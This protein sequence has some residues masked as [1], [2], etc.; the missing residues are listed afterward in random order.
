MHYVNKCIKLPRGSFLGR[1]LSLSTPA[2]TAGHAA[3]YAMTTHD[4]CAVGKGGRSLKLI[5]HLPPILPKM[6]RTLP[7]LPLY[8]FWDGAR[9]DREDC[10]TCLTRTRAE[11]VVSV[12]YTFSHS[13]HLQW[14]VNQQTAECSTQ[15]SKSTI[16]AHTPVQTFITY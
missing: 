13:I 3:S 5:I 14:G 15:V 4:L 8:A 2:P 6:R 7:H 10:L 16:R 1:S 12:L 11:T 9:K